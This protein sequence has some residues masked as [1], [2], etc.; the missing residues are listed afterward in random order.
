MKLAE[1]A[2][3]TKHRNRIGH[4]ISVPRRRIGRHNEVAQLEGLKN[5][6]VVLRQPEG[7]TVRERR[8]EEMQIQPSLQSWKYDE[9]DRE[10][11]HSHELRSARLDQQSRRDH[12]D[13]NGAVGHAD[14]DGQ[15]DQNPAERG[16]GQALFFFGIQKRQHRENYDGKRRNVT[17]HAS[18]KPEKM[19][20]CSEEQPG[21][22]RAWPVEH[23][24]R[25]QI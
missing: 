4:R 1:D 23:P 14:R 19:R 12:S 6:A 18:G 16:R 2:V 7:V 15:A 10:R 9:S 25:Q 8:T 24:Q 13:Q 21:H 20:R 17:Q 3:E 22:N 5:R 11:C